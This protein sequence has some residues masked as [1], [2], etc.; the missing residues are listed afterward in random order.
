MKLKKL[1]S[2]ILSCALAGAVFA[3]CGSSVTEQ[4]SSSTDSDKPVRVG[5]IAYLNASEEVINSIMK[6]VDADA[7]KSGGKVINP[8]TYIYF[9][10]LTA[11]QMALGSDKIDEMSTYK[12]VATYMMGKEK[13]LATAED[14][15][16]V[17]SD[18]FCCAV[19]KDDVSLKSGI[20]K[21][22]KEMKS[23][24]TLDRLVKTYITD[25]KP[26]EEP[27]AVEVPK[28]E[29]ADTLKIAVTGDIPPLDLVLA[30]GKPAGFNT[31]VLAEL[32]KRLGKNVEFVSIESK[33]RAS[34]LVSRRVDVVFWA[35]VPTDTSYRPA[36]I[37]QPD[38][39]AV[40]EPYYQDNLSHLVLKKK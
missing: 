30:D 25:L 6:K 10:N 34:A 11:M 13:D 36:D 24:G 38:G 20:D 14:D 33:A 19:R 15:L 27:K 18:N 2:V 39:I 32:S 40:T 26:G 29:G 37:D 17:L 3:G 1:A 8:R 23:D 35:A 12:S 31:A 21:A 22:I 16:A 7:Q 5:M 4:K 9:D 28:I